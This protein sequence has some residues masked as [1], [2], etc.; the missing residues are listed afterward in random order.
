VLRRV[1]V[2]FLGVCVPTLAWGAAD[3]ATP[4]RAVFSVTLTATLTKDWTVSRST[5]EGDCTQTTTSA[6]HWRMSLAT[7]RPSRL[8]FTSAGRGPIRISPAVVQAL[9]GTARQ[10]GSM[11]TVSRGPG[12]VGSLR[13]DCGPRRATVGN[14]SARLTSPRF[15]V[16]RFARLQRAASVRFRGSCPEEPE[17]VRSIRTDLTLA[18]APL[19]ASDVLSRDVPRFFISGNTTQETTIEGEYDGKVTERARWTL[20]FTRVR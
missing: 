15:G 6:G 14:A 18:D 2:L 17:E 1:G 3:A 20:T 10:I 16:A 4:K 9:A 19:S 8:G 7:R 11:R 5:V 12:C 13:R